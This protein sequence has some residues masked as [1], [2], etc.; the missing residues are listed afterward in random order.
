M[1]AAESCTRIGAVPV[2]LTPFP[3]DPGGMTPVQVGPWL[4]LR[5]SIMT[6]RETGAVV[7]DATDLFGRRSEGVLDGRYLPEYSNDDAHPNNAAHAAL[8]GCLAR[9]IEG[10]YELPTKMPF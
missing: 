6:L 3:R 5:D 4:K 8:A 2:F 1:M 9:V 7:L 10:L